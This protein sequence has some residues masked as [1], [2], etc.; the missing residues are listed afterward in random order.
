MVDSSIL[1]YTKLII[2]TLFSN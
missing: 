1:N 2:Q